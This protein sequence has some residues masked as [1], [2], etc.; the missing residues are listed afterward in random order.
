MYHGW[1]DPQVPPYT[2]IRYFNNVLGTVGKDA[3]NSIALFM[4]PGMN[5]CQ[6]GPGV[7][8]FDKIGVLE[9]WV[10]RGVKP[11][12]IVAAHL[13]NSKVD[14][15]RP[16]CPLGEIAKYNGTGDVNNAVNFTCT[17]VQ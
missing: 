12:R 11:S 15:T 4:V 14:K 16:L 13:T 10:E 3:E 5:H 6:G 8:T 2:S 17:P 9:Q 1:S 7:D